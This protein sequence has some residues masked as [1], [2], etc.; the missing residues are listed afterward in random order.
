MKYFI[1]SF[2]LFIGLFSINVTAQTMNNDNPFFTEYTTPFQT[3]PF[4]KIKLRFHRSYETE[5]IGDQSILS[6]YNIVLTHEIYAKYIHGNNDSCVL[7]TLLKNTNTSL[8]W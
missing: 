3:P 2:I 8:N 6:K 1:C 4:D 5:P 7:N